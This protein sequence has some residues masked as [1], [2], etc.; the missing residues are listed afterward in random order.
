MLK[1]GGDCVEITTFKKDYLPDMAGIFI[2]NFKQLRS[3]VPTVPNLMEEPDRVID[4]LSRLFDRCPGVVALAGGTVLGYM[5]WLIADHFRGTERKGAY[6]PEWGHGAIQE[7]RPQVYRAMYRAA[8][9]V[10]AESG[11]QVHALTLL[12]HDRPAE[13]V[14]FW[15]GFGLTVV[16]AIRSTCP[17]GGNS[18]S[19]IYIRKATQDDI[20]TLAQMEIEHGEHFRQPPV[21]MEAYKPVD[22]AGLS[23]FLDEPGNSIWLAMDGKNVMG[24]LRFETNN[25]DCVAVVRA[26]DN[27]SNTGAYIR[28]AY[29]GR[30][31]AAATLD[32]AL[33]DYASQGF[34]RCS[35]DF[36]SFNPEAAG[37]WIRY[38]E[39]VAY[40]VLRVPE[41]EYSSG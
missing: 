18:S 35:V 17:L 29:R 7:T 21:L 4:R 3:S 9:Q 31:A 20:E 30:G 32:A 33:R 5:G 23:R 37:F 34:R 25:D 24:Y 27:I 16:D 10:W 11:F 22:A 14:W 41:R 28:P 19:D 8:S 36:E 6:C 2:H 1:L 40:S 13:K 26:P 39:P 38:F 12:A 15:N